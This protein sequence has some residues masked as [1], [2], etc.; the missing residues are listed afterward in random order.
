MRS[1]SRFANL[2]NYVIA[3]NNQRSIFTEEQAAAST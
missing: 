3:S 1:V 2:L